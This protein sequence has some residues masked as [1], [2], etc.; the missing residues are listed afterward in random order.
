MITNEII[1]GVLHSPFELP[2]EMWQNFHF[3]VN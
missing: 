1:S 2:Q 3:W